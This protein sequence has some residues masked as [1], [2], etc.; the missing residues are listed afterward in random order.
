MRPHPRF[1]K[2]ITSAVLSAGALLSFFVPPVAA[3]RHAPPH[4]HRLSHATH[5]RPRRTHRHGAARTSSVHPAARGRSPHTTV[6][7]HVVHV[8]ATAVP[9]GGVW[10]RLRDCESAGNYHED[11]GNGYYGAYQFSLATWHS[12]GGQGRPDEAGVAVQDALAR[13]L[14]AVAGWRSWPSCSW[15]LGL[16]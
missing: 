10:A 14:E 4:R 2:P 13:R 7:T 8:A 1:T 16:M 11:T 5:H 6:R 12:M 3:A 15:E 9:A